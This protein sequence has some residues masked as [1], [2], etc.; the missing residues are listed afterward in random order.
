VDDNAASRLKAHIRRGTAFCELEL[1]AEGLMDYEAALKIEPNN[2]EIAEDAANIR[3]I[4]L[5]SPPEF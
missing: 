1:Y 2:S 5:G 3:K 4:I